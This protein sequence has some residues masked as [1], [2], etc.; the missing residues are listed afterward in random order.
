MT[1]LV[2]GIIGAAAL[3]FAVLR[4]ETRTGKN[5]LPRRKTT[6]G[7]RRWR[8]SYSAGVAEDLKKRRYADDLR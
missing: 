1:W 2:I 5:G 6:F 4:Q 3:L 8:P 7:D